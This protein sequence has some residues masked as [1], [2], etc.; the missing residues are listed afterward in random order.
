M[1]GKLYGKDNPKYSHGKS[2]TRIYKRYYDIKTR[3]YNP[4]YKKFENYGGRG[5]KVCDEWLNDFQV[6]YDW[7]IANGYKDGLEIERIENDGDYTPD[8]CK[9]AT[10]SDQM[11]NT[12]MYLN[13]KSGYKGVSWHKANNKWVVQIGLNG[14][15]LC[16][17]YYEDI[18][19]AVK[20]RKDAELKYWG[21][22]A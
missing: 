8:N 18:N 4:K 2:Y 14:K 7:S 22:C 17:G 6:F 13:N 11:K 12:G 10:R 15:R 20:A 19:D 3:C 5:I 9:W 1:G 16:V 21:E